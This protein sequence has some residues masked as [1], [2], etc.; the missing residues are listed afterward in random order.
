VSP[1]SLP[2]GH[3]VTA[4]IDLPLDSGGQTRA[5]LMRN[6]ILVQDAGVRASVFTFAAYPD[7]AGHVAEL[8]RRGLLI[9]EIAVENIYDHLREHGWPA[10]LG[11]GTEPQPLPALDATRVDEEQRADGSP[12][13][14]I[15]RTPQGRVLDYLRADGSTYLR[16]PG[17][18]FR[19]S[20]TWPT[21]VLAVDE[22][23][24]VVHDFGSLHGW[25]THWVERMT[26]GERTFLFIDSR[27]AAQHLLPLRLPQVHP[28]YVLHNIHVEPPR[29]WSSPTPEMYGRVLDG[30][31]GLDAFVTITRR[32]RDDIAR[33]LGERTSL[34]HVP[35]AVDVMPE[36]DRSQERDPHRVSLVAR[37]SAQ[38]RVIDAVR[39]IDLVRRSV[40]EVRFHVYGDGPRR[41]RIEKEVERLGLQEHVTLFGHDGHAKETLT[42]SSAFLVTSTFE[43]WNL[44]MQEAMS[45]G[46]PVVAYDIKYGPREQID[47]GVD[48]FL[49]PDGDL[50][51]MAE[52]VVRL[53]TSP[54]LVRQLGERARDRTAHSRERFVDDWAAVLDAVV[55][56]RPRHL[57]G[58]GLRTRSA[59]AELVGGGGLL[60]RRPRTLEVRAE[61]RLSVDGAGDSAPDLGWQLAAVNTRT[62]GF[63]EIP[64]EVDA[65]DDRTFRVRGRV[66]VDDLPR[67]CRL[68]LTVSAENA[69]AQRM[70]R[71]RE[72]VALG[73]LRDGS[74][75]ERED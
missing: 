54:D 73:L 32:Q 36:V 45:R 10:D 28:I 1:R 19:Q 20:D 34:F 26:A 71:S 68:R 74:L 37:L 52:R 24:R 50:E 25:F 59:R 23:E 8:C 67:P 48:G 30:L 4:P 51:A 5:L 22:S 55:E 46:C 15:H 40:P 72:G 12:W 63:A 21:S 27:Y 57:D 3:Y 70:L 42:T 56:Q 7:L 35:H 66:E 6:R 62:G 58:L 18:V 49:V 53:L 14:R 43:G 64:V 31:D 60:R 16:V 65:V 11:A 9:P 38:K 2:P 13:R 75:R 17:F 39:V 29:H 47:D 41:E 33:R 69:A 44:A 61:V